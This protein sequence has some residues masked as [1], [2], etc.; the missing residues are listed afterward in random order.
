MRDFKIFSPYHICAIQEDINIHR[1]RYISPDTPQPAKPGLYH[2]RLLKHFPWLQG[3]CD[4]DHHVKE[5]LVAK[6]TPWL[7]LING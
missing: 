5:R 4:P 1:P 7:G 2:K 6:E 3:G